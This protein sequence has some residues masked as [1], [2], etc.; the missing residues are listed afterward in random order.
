MIIELPIDSP[1]RSPG[2]LFG[3]STSSFQIEGA[4]DSRLESIWDR[5][6]DTPGKILDGSNGK[7]ACEHVRRYEEDVALMANLG[8]DAYRLSISWPRVI[9]RDGSLNAQ[10]LGFYKNLLDCLNKNDIKPFV[11]L[12]HWDLPQFLEERGGWL[13]RDIAFRFRDYVDIVSR[14]LGERVYSFAT[15]NEPL[16]SARLS[17]ELGL[18]AP[19]FK[20]RG[21][22]KQAA[23][24]LLLAHGLA[25]PVL[26]ENC[27]NA[28]SGIVLN[29]TPCHPV[30][31][32]EADRQ[33]A[34]WADHDFNQ[35]YAQPVL[36]GG[37][38]ALYEQLP[39]HERPEV[40]DGD[41]EKICQPLDFLGV[42]YYTR[43]LFRAAAESL[44][45]NV[46]PAGVPLTDMGWEIYPEGLDEV[47]AML[48]SK[49]D[50]PP[51]FIT[52][53]GIAIKGE[54]PD[55]NIHDPERTRYLATHLQALDRAMKAGAD[56]RGY[57]AWSLMDNFEWNYGFSR[58][59]G[60][61][62]IDYSSQKRT[63]KA[64]GQAFREML[65]RRRHGG[66]G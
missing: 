24:H 45:E 22:A 21:M 5:F 63:L 58:R 50:V 14:E 36:S 15:L 56:V 26:R 7:T 44:F 54:T 2:F 42:N 19:G 32:S 28:M 52:E 27:P 66:R 20:D 61:V 33:A 23:H 10:G 41:F 29:L 16:C 1:M 62:H 65:K 30:S 35:W 43:G 55:G 60:L 3:I 13:N 38:P 12:Y 59:F 49:Y 37:Y 8:V 9:N 18:H 4:T 11:T 46:S 6:C 39:D 40:M 25:M 48:Y 51:V 34:E 57:F 47:L 53:N 17:Y 31:D 64:S